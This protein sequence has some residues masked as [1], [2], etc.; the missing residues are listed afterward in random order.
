LHTVQCHP[1]LDP[2]Q[3]PGYG[4][5]WLGSGQS[6]GYGDPWLDPGQSPGYEEGLPGAIPRSNPGVGRAPA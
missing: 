1:A 2:G 3:S 6:P 4:D 5:P